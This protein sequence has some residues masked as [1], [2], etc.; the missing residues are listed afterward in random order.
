ML[1]YFHLYLSFAI[2]SKSAVINLGV[3]VNANSHNTLHDLLHLYLNFNFFQCLFCVY[4]Q[5]MYHWFSLSELLQ[6]F[7]ICL[8]HLSLH[9]W[10][11]F[12]ILDRFVTAYLWILAHWFDLKLFFKLYDFYEYLIDSLFVQRCFHDQLEA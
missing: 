2:A 8:K 3:K 4:K 9:V 10:V 6:T 5:F 7:A 1:L 12:R 11:S